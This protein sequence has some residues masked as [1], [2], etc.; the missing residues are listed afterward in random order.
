MRF[1]YI[2]MT[3]AYTPFLM[4]SNKY[5]YQTQKE[6]KVVS[7]ENKTKDGG[8]KKRLLRATYASYQ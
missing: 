3:C 1:V 2:V 5:S 6:A 4:R 7:S 8:G